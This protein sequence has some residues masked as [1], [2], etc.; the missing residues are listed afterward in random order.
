MCSLLTTSPF[1]TC[2]LPLFSAGRVYW[3]SLKVYTDYGIQGCVTF[4]LEGDPLS[5][6]CSDLLVPVGSLGSLQE[7]CSD[8]CLGVNCWSLKFLSGFPGGSV[9]PAIQETRV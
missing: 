2:N 4:I 8:S 9:V 7:C 5:G 6:V 3:C 1:N